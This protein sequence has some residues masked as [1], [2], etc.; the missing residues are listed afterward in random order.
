LADEG[1]AV[2]AK[3]PY[4]RKGDIS[5]AYQVVGDGPVD[6]VLA[7]AGLFA[8]LRPHSRPSLFAGLCG[9]LST[10]LAADGGLRPYPGRVAVPVRWL[11]SGPP[12]AGHHVHVGRDIT[13]IGAFA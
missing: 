5:I 10:V 2:A 1:I 7:G 8:A 6:L 13:G 3:T 11:L 4:A 9:L 12:K